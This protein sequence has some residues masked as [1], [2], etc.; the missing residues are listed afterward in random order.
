MR[1]DYKC[2]CGHIKENVIHGAFEAPEIICSRCGGIMW[3]LMNS[4]HFNGGETANKDVWDMTTNSYQSVDQIK[5]REQSGEIAMMTW[6][7]QKRQTKENYEH[8]KAEFKKKNDNELIKTL[9]DKN[10]L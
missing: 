8:N 6:D 3:K 9:K 10:L 7:E 1:Y 2:D 4:F 5:K